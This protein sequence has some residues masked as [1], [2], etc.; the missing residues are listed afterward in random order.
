MTVRPDVLQ[1]EKKKMKDSGEV[2]VTVTKEL[3]WGWGE[4]VFKVT[5]SLANPKVRG[6]LRVR[7]GAHKL[8][9]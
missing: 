8:A 5:G 7:T 6:A 9:L 1:G 4:A 3:E 2:S